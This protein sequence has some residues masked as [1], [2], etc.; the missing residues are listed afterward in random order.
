MSQRRPAP[1]RFRA[2]FPIIRAAGLLPST[3]AFALL[4]AVTTVILVIAEPGID[5]LGD[6]AWVLFQAVTTIGYG[7]FTCVTPFGRIAIV[8]LSIYS[9]FFIAL[10]TGTVVTYCSERMKAERDES[11][12]QFIDQLEHLHEL[13]REDLAKLSERVRHFRHH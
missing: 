4:F 7:D 1:L 13:S 10:V 2:I 8:I 9:V 12:A 3:A 5:T 11:A 6:G